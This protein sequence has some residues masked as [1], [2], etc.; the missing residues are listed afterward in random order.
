M[1]RPNWTIIKEFPVV[2]EVCEELAVLMTLKRIR[3]MYD[4]IRKDAETFKAIRRDTD[5]VCG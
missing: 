4:R 1:F 3:N 2:E 5:M